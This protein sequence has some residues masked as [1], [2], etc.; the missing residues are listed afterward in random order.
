MLLSPLGVVGLWLMLRLETPADGR[1][2]LRITATPGAPQ[3]L[4]W[5]GFMVMLCAAVTAFD[6]VV[7]GQ[8]WHDSLKWYHVGL[9]LPLII[10][11][12]AGVWMIEKRHRSVRQ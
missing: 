3:L 1:P 4:A 6:M 12:F 8:G 5:L 7:L 2:T 9:Y 11:I 10:M